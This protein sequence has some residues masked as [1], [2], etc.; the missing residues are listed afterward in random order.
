LNRK[1]IFKIVFF[2]NIGVGILFCVIAVLYFEQAFKGINL[3]KIILAIMILTISFLLLVN[4]Y[5]FV[6]LKL[7]HSPMVDYF[8]SW[9]V[10]WRALLPRFL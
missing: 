9:H 1:K 7:L 6:K 8:L 2:G 10:A 5:G 3:S 4:I